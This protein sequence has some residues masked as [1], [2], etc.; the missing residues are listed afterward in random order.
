M[1]INESPDELKGS[2]AGS[3]TSEGKNE[4]EN[5]IE[6]VDDY[7]SRFWERLKFLETLWKKY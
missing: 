2:Q 3:K 1:K 5:Y 6:V 7:T 4:V